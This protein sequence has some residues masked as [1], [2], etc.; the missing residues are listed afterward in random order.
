VTSI[1]LEEG[2]R[3]HLNG[4]PVFLNNSC[5]VRVHGGNL[6]LIGAISREGDDDE[7][8]TDSDTAATC[9]HGAAG[10]EELHMRYS[11]VDLAMR[12]GLATSFVALTDC[13][14]KIYDF[15]KNGPSKASE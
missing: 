11:A 3:L 9:S 14:S 4:I 1:L 15:L 12:S 2:T 7:G 10:D 5:A 6:N 8:V 13:A